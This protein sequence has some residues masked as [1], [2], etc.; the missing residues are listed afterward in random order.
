MVLRKSAKHKKGY[1]FSEAELHLIRSGALSLMHEHERHLQGVERARHRCTGSGSAHALVQA[2][3]RMKSESGGTI[4]N[5]PNPW[6]QGD[7]G[8]PCLLG[9][10]NFASR[11]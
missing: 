3:P 2:M 11:R 4:G 1:S 5:R 9:A 7:S 8:L 6:I 10:T